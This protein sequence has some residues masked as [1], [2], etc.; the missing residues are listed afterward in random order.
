MSEQNRVALPLAFSPVGL[1]DVPELN[2]LI[3]AAACQGG[4][5]GFEVYRP[6]SA[7]VSL[8]DLN[9]GGCSDVQ[10]VYESSLG[11]HSELQSC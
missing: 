5:V 4:P 1:L 8:E 7:F 3:R 10:Q 9:N 2:Q 11:P 6:D